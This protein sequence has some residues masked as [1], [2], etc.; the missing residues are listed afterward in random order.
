MRARTVLVGFVE[1]VRAL[2]SMVVIEARLR[3]GDLPTVCRRSGVRLDLT[4]ADPAAG[5]AVLPRWTRPAIRVSHVVVGLWP[6]GS[7]LRRCLLVGHRLRELDPVLRIGV[8]R[9]GGHRFAAHS[10][11]EIDGGSL[12]P[13]AGDFAVLAAPTPPRPS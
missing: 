6:G 10:W 4:S 3:T 9:D 13:T 7:C 1:L 5:P 8:R 12:D 11:L 2:A